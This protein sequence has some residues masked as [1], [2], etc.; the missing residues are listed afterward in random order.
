MI[1]SEAQLSIHRHRSVVVRAQWVACNYNNTANCQASPTFIHVSVQLH[2][3][4]AAGS[5]T[6][7]TVFARALRSSL[8]CARHFPR[9]P[10]CVD[11]PAGASMLQSNTN[12]ITLIIHTLLV[13]GVIT[14]SASNPY[15]NGSPS[16]AYNGTVY[17]SPV[18]HITAA[19]L[20]AKIRLLTY[21][22][23]ARMTD[24]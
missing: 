8:Q 16:T 18:P 3:P 22:T 14:V 24:M 7:T 9:A 13:S 5:I 17:G 12:S 6:G 2:F 20:F 1:T 15:G 10:A 11:I 23:R 19:T 4:P 21:P